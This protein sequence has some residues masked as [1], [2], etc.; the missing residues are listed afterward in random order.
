MRTLP[1]PLPQATRFI[2]RRIGCE[3]GDCGA[4]PT[5]ATVK[6]VP[7]HPVYQHSE[8]VIGKPWRVCRVHGLWTEEQIRWYIASEPHWQGHGPTLEVVWDAAM[9]LEGI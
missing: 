3:C 6:P 7:S 8:V 9:S 1:Q 2:R 4:V 5:A